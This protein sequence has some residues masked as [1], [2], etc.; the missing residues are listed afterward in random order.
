MASKKSIK[1]YRK[2]TTKRRTAYRDT[3]ANILIVGATGVGKSST[4]NALIGEGTAKAGTGTDPETMTVTPH[5]FNKFITLWDTPGLGDGIEIDKKHSKLITDTLKM[6]RKD[7]I[8]G[9]NVGV[10]DLVLVIIEGSARDMGTIF[11][12][13][14]DVIIPNFPTN[15]IIVAELT[16]KILQSGDRVISVNNNNIAIERVNG[17]VE[18]IPVIIDENGFPGIDTAHT[19]RI[20]YGSGATE[21]KMNEG[22][23]DEF[24]AFSF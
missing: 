11:R 10:I 15:R 9:K 23:D 19:L 18:I 14:N 13:L 3:P 20:T 5:R 2:T 8:T 12:L 16:L 6:S 24:T 4:L 1:S 21:V 22:S 17:E 7:N